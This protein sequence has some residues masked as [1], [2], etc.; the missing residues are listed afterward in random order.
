[1]ILLARRS[2]VLEVSAVATFLSS[3]GFS[4]AL[5]HA[6]SYSRERALHS[7]PRSTDGGCGRIHT[8]TPLSLRVSLHVFVSAYM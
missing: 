2:R 4:V 8:G 5:P 6:S 1:M 7:C 3:V